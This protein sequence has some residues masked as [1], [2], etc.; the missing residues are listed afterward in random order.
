MTCKP[1]QKV[2][3]YQWW[4]GVVPFEQADLYKR[5]RCWRTVGVF[6]F[7]ASARRSI[8]WPVA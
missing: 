1:A 2:V 7:L 5:L 6:Y 8:S 4:V 3:Q